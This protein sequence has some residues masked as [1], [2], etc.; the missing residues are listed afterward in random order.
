MHHTIAEFMI[1]ANKS[2]A[3]K[4][5]SV[6]PTCS[7]L[8]HHRPPTAAKLEPLVRMVE[9]TGKG[10]WAIDGSSNLAL[11]RSMHAIEQQLHDSVLSRATSASDP[12]RLERAEAL[13]GMLRTMAVRAMSEAHYFST[14]DRPVDEFAH[15]G[16][17]A[18]FYTHF[19]SPIRRY[20]DVVVH[21][22][23]LA[24]V[25]VS[26][27]YL[28]LDARTVARAAQGGA[29]FTAQ[30]RARFPLLFNAA[31]SSS[32]TDHAPSSAEQAS[33]A[34]MSS[35]PFNNRALGVLCDHINRRHR[36]AKFVSAESQALYLSM[37]LRSQGAQRARAVVYAVRDNGLL[38]L[39]PR[40]QLRGAVLLQ[41]RDGCCVLSPYDRDTC[42][43]LDVPAA[44]STQSGINGAL[45]RSNELDQ[46]ATDEPALDNTRA[47][48]R[49]ISRF[50]ILLDQL[51]VLYQLL[52][53]GA[54][55]TVLFRAPLFR[56]ASTKRSP[57]SPA[58]QR[59]SGLTGGL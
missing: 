55:L 39:V 10:A 28:E 1:L 17:A 50:L 56:S 14:G 58:E 45:T 5:Y 26:G 6:F 16:L 42:Q 47:M 38:V 35:A 25:S 21:R 12:D 13:I 52:L 43:D 20:A 57:S 37:Y 11:A 23:L 48:V 22:Q 36:S 29:A 44:A 8:R 24:A 27:P 54:D 31:L 2:V 19:T 41:D 32:T 15:Y 3:E 4:L 18:A 34:A 9:S 40:Y 53:N 46:L 51:L 33:I 7:L 59:M 49:V 30:Q